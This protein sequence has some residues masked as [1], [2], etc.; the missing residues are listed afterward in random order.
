[1][2]DVS[3][4]VALK[5]ELEEAKT[6]LSERKGELKGLLK[7]LKDEFKVSTIEEAEKKMNALDVEIAEMEASI[8]TKIQQLEEEYDLEV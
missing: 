8:N 5:E 7:Q 6:T 1:M 2:I 4:F 3:K